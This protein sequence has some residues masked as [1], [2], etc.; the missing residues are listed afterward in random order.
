MFP[1]LI[2]RNLYYQVLSI[3]KRW[4]CK[5]FFVHFCKL[6]NM[7]LKKSQDFILKCRDISWKVVILLW[8]EIE[9]LMTFMNS[10][11]ILRLVEILSWM[12]RIFKRAG[13]D[14]IMNGR[15]ILRWISMVVLVLAVLV[16]MCLQPKKMEV[17]YGYFM[18]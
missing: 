18:K 2:V 12:V 9:T 10:W 3:C 5:I 14:S 8:T 16:K 6:W 13:W 1:Y 17:Q 11:D 4:M 15:W 7:I